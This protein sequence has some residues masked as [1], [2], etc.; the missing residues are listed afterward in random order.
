MSHQARPVVLYQARRVATQA[1]AA[2]GA[3][4][5]DI[6]PAA[7]QTIRL[8]SLVA[9]NSGTNDMV[10]ETVDE[11]NARSGYFGAVA[12]AAAVKINLPTIGAAGS[13]SSNLATSE[14]LRIPVGEKLVVKQSGAGAQND[15]LTVA[16]VL[17]LIGNGT[18]PTWSKAR[19][20][21]EADVTLA[22]NTIS[23]PIK[24]ALEPIA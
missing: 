20:T 17:E 22:A 15:T 11:D 1:N 6:T 14:N 5:I 24:V 9:T 13:S 7:G 3:V 4:V 23:T 8:I 2:G 19:S 12:S 16:V 10:V 18:E 21:N